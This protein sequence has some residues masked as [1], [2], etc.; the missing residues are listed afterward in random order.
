MAEKQSDGTF[1]PAFL[2]MAPR[3]GTGT[4]VGHSYYEGN[5]VHTAVHRREVISPVIPTE[6]LLSTN[7]T[8]NDV[9]ARLPMV[10]SSIGP[11]ELTVSLE[12]RV[13]ATIFQDYTPHEV[14]IDVVEAEFTSEAVIRLREVGQRDTVRFRGLVRHVARAFDSDL[15]FAAQPELID[16]FWSE[17]GDVEAEEWRT[18]ISEVVHEFLGNKAEVALHEELMQML[19]AW[20]ERGEI[21]QS[22][23]A[24]VLGTP[25][26]IFFCSWVLRPLE[27]SLP[28]SVRLVYPFAVVLKRA[29]AS[30]AGAEVKP[31]I[32]MINEAMQKAG[33]LVRQE[34]EEFLHYQAAYES[35]TDDPEDQPGDKTTALRRSHF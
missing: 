25:Y 31:L 21:A 34:L 24:K 7:M 1:V 5:E 4:G 32:G 17:E 6:E 35:A 18:R 10:L 3:T 14:E 2:S 20:S 13:S 16:D 22:E 30:P 28:K 8:V 11:A 15:R 23:M 9:M 29:A 26:G 27:M 12:Y 33:P 19:A